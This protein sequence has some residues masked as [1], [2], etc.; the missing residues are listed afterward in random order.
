LPVVTS[1]NWDLSECIFFISSGKKKYRTEAIKRLGELEWNESET[2]VSEEFQEVLRF[3]GV[4]DQLACLLILCEK[5]I[6]S[7]DLE[8]LDSLIEKNKDYQIKKN[9]NLL[10]QQITAQKQDLKFKKSKKIKKTKN[11]MMPTSSESPVL[12]WTAQQEQAL[13]ALSNFLSTDSEKIFVLSGYAGTGKS[14]LCSEILKRFQHKIF[15]LTASTNKAVSVLS[16]MSLKLGSN[17][18]CVT[19]HKLL[20]LVPSSKFHG[21]FLQQTRK[22]NL[23]NA[24]V[25]VVDECSMVNDELMHYIEKLVSNNPIQIIFVGDP[26]QLPPV[27]EKM[28]STFGSENG[29]ELSEI[30]RQAAGNP[31]I[32]MTMKIR[33]SIKNND[34]N[35]D[36]V[37]GCVKSNENLR[38][39]ESEKDWLL[40]IKRK[41]IKNQS[42]K[43]KYCILTWSNKRVAKL[44]FYVESLKRDVEKEPF[45]KFQQVLVKKPIFRY[46]GDKVTKCLIQTDSICVVI[47]SKLFK[48]NDLDVWYVKLKNSLGVIAEVFYAKEGVQEILKG[49]INEL[50]KIRVKIENKSFSIEKIL[51]NC[52]SIQYL[53]AITVHRSQGTTYDGVFVDLPKILQNTNII[54]SYKMLYVALTRT[55]ESVVL[56]K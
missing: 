11:L 12:N 20:N 35:F 27:N 34:F 44:N 54:E 42:E 49:N 18:P 43:K 39:C 32:E 45:E 37:L 17:N 25:V 36:S 19:I 52:N 33:E 1:S 10:L 31:I 55:K 5:N 3:G 40:E 30:V 16:E 46:F 14:S 2:E 51:N 7:I 15:L 22:P 28:S 24:E 56:W 8:L 29:Y 47:K 6:L 21:G 9:A 26:M 23:K 48:I 53:H 4:G 13:V 50:E 38:I 41:F